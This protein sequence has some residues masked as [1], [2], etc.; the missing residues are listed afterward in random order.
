MSR[1]LNVNRPEAYFVMIDH[2]PGKRS[3]LVAPLDRVEISSDDYD[4]TTFG[5]E[6]ER[7][8]RSHSISAKIREHTVAMGRS[9]ARKLRNAIRESIK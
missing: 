1:P 4:I 3:V 5:D 8:L 7:R 6:F 2:T 9:R